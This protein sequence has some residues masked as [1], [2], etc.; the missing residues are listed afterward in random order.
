MAVV[1]MVRERVEATPNHYF[2]IS[3]GFGGSKVGET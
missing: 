2:D 1:G 3:G